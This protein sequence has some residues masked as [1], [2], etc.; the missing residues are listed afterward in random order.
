MKI[1]LDS[2][3]IIAEINSSFMNDIDFLVEIVD[4]GTNTWEPYREVVSKL[5]QNLID[6]DELGD[7]KELITN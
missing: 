5:I 6:N 3:D 1:E 2:K 7:I 4:E